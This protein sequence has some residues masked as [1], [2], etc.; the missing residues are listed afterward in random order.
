MSRNNQRKRLW[1]I[2]GTSALAAGLLGLAYAR[3]IEPSLLDITYHRLVL[4]RL[5]PEFHDYRLV[6]ISDIHMDKRMQSRLDDIVAAVNLQ[7][8]DLVAITGDFVTHSVHKF[9]P[10]LVSSLRNLRAPDGVAA[11]MGN[12]DH[13]SGPD[14]VRRMIHDSGIRDLNNKSY[15]IRRGQAALHIA[16]VD[17]YMQREDRLDLVLEQ[18]PDEGAAIL[19]AHEPDYAEVSAASGRFD[20]QLSGH[21]HGGQ[22]H[23]P[24]IGAPFLPEHAGKYPRGLYHI[25][26]MQIYTNRG[27]G[28]VHLNL[29][30]NSLPEV[31]VFI[32]EA[33]DG[34]E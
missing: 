13:W 15:T 31:S 20:L 8:P 6:Q 23:L 26:G 10:R 14:E 2:L 21:S 16:G 34:K 1:D 22:V 32:L 27:L 29:R 3:R 5:A 17:D 24:F 11:I 30:W 12:H 18:I 9:A 28:M 33:G 19:L 4:P 25:N 7:N